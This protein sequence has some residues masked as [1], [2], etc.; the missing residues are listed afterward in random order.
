M[1][2]AARI[3]ANQNEIVNG[4]RRAGVKVYILGLPLD[5]L[6]GWKGVLRILEVKDGGNTK[7]RRK[8]RPGQEK[9]INEWADCPVFKVENL[10]QAYDA[11][12]IKVI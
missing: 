1:R 11:H 8:L 2:Y 12:G 4:L 3:D 9:F 6:T 5:L 10:A 7:S